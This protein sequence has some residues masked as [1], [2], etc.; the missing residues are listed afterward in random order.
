MSNLKILTIIT[1][2]TLSLASPA[3]ANAAAAEIQLCDTTE[4]RPC[5]K[6]GCS[7]PV[8]CTKN[9]WDHYRLIEDPR[10]PVDCLKCGIY[11]SCPEEAGRIQEAWEKAHPHCCSPPFAPSAC[12]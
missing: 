2:A 6:V 8:L 10:G 7:G 12:Q 4:K 11:V 9:N 3:V 1:V 5:V